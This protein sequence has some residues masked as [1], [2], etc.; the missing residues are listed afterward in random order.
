MRDAWLNLR[1]N[2]LAER[3]QRIAE[4]NRAALLA[5]HNYL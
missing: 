3:E 2:V 4:A 1:T 5:R